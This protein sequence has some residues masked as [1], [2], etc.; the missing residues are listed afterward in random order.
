M[1]LGWVHEDDIFREGSIARRSSDASKMGVFCHVR[2]RT[3]KRVLGAESAVA[4]QMDGD[5]V[6]QDRLMDGVDVRSS[7]E[8]A[9]FK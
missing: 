6:P 4:F 8:R 2:L 1:L 7:Y 5:N 3:L 9:S